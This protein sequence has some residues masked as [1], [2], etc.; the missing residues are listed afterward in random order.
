VE[1]S[2]DEAKLTMNVEAESRIRN[3]VHWVE[4]GEEALNFYR[5]EIDIVSH[6]EIARFSKAPPPDSS[7]PA[8]PTLAQT[9]Q[10]TRDLPAALTLR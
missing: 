4:D 2:T 8:R 10:C 9:F 5:S 3:R 7:L 6:E 1:D